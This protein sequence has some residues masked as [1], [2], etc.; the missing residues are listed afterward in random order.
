MQEREEGS[1]LGGTWLPDSPASPH[2]SLGTLMLNPLPRGLGPEVLNPG[3]LLTPRMGN[4]PPEGAGSITVCVNRVDFSGGESLSIQILRRV[5]GS[6]EN[7]E[8]LC[9]LSLD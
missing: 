9:R 5:P 4:I 6:T 1:R 8:N 2:S 3:V 7:P